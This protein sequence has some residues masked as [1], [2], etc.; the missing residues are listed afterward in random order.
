MFLPPPP[1]CLDSPHDEAIFGSK[2]HQ[3]AG[4]SPSRRSFSAKSQN[5]QK[6]EFMERISVPTVA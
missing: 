3:R 1:A 5:L 2:R 4:V 6:V